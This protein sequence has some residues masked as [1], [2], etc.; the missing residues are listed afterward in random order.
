MNDKITI[1]PQYLGGEVKIPPSKSM[2]HRYIIGA[3]L[4]KQE[5]IIKN[6]EASKEESQ[7]ITGTLCTAAAISLISEASFSIA[8]PTTITSAPALQ[9]R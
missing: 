4:S 5:V 2:A 6:I 9:F 3:A 7:I 1:Y 8:L